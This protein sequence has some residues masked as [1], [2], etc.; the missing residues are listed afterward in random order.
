MDVPAVSREFREAH[1]LPASAPIFGVFGALSA[2]KRVREIVAAFAETRAWVPDAV[3]LLAGSADAWLDLDGY[4]KEL[5]LGDAVR[6]LPKLD[7]RE[8]DR[9]I[10]ATDVV[11]SLRWPTALETSGPWV[12]A[13]ALGRATVI[14]DLPHQTHVP[15][16]DPRTW[17]RHAPCSDLEPNADDRAIAVAVDL[18][19]VAHSLRL[20]LRRLG[21]DAALRHALGLRARRWWEREHTV[22]R[23]TDDYERVLERARITPPP[24]V[25]PD[26]PLH[27]RPEPGADARSLFLDPIWRDATL[28]A[29]MASLDTCSTIDGL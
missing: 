11:L 23:M 16:L 20:A 27:L 17:R 1:S 13:L 6:L 29:C 3:L 21:Q 10:A 19:D 7:D 9:A 5:G 4:I 8:F 25:L 26:W 12:R 14:M 15:T 2:E 22:A 24:V 28:D 18:V